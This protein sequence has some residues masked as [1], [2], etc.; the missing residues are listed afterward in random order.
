MTL[1]PQTYIN[2]RLAQVTRSPL[3]P[4]ELRRRLLAVLG[5]METWERPPLLPRITD[6]IQ[7]DGYRRE[8]VT[9]TSRPGLTLFG[10]FLTPDGMKDG[11]RRPGILCLPGHGS[12]VA[13]DVGIL[14]EGR[15]LRIGESDEYHAMFALQCVAQGYP[16]FA[17]EQIGFG[18]RRGDS[19]KAQGPYQTSCHG[20]SMAALMLGETMIGW[21]VWDAFRALDY[22]QICPHVD[23]ARLVTMGISGGGLT[24]LFVAALDNRVSACVVSGYLNTFRDSVLGVFHCV[25]NYAQG[26][27]D[28]AEMEDIAA[29][30]APRPLYA[31][32]G[33]TDHIFPIAGFHKVVAATEK[34]YADLGVPE[35]FCTSIFSG[36]HRFDGTGLWPFLQAQLR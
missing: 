23:P 28:L 33:D 2:E 3:E 20:D 31:E 8:R 6:T 22:L 24:S 25:D 30:V 27:F 9:L 34:R 11:E 10:Y 36:G 17:I 1:N 7:L 19:F 18:E 4:D 13:S 16:T 21:R 14:P 12:G 29:L 35:R 5:S 26:L 32:N 15:Q